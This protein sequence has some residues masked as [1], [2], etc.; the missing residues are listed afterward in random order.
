MPGSMNEI[1]QSGA[2]ITDSMASRKKPMMA[3]T[4]TRNGTMGRY[5]ARKPPRMANQRLRVMNNALTILIDSP[6]KPPAYDHNFDEIN[7]TIDVVPP[8]PTI[9]PDMV[10]KP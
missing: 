9:T 5:I 2:A 8:K 4:H 7:A 3:P 6:T 1:A 10:R